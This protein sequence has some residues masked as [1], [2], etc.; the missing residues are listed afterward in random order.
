MTESDLRAGVIRQVLRHAA[1]IVGITDS[2]LADTLNDLAD[3]YVGP[4][5]ETE[6]S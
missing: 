1:R 6:T 3:D 4:Y 2:G 5:T